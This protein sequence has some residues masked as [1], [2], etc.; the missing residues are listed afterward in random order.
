M[1][2]DVRGLIDSIQLKKMRNGYGNVWLH[3]ASIPN[4]N[5]PLGDEHVVFL[6]TKTS[7]L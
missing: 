5:I 6:L 7:W 2:L 1:I 3:I 4:G